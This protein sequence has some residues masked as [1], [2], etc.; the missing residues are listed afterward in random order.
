MH[1][2]SGRHLLYWALPKCSHI[3]L[4]NMIKKKRAAD[5]IGLIA[6]TGPRETSEKWKIFKTSNEK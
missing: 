2:S 1:V 3:L 4:V 6:V 5:A